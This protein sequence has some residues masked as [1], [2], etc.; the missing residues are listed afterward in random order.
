MSA[1]D[2]L[3]NIEGSTRNAI[4]IILSKM[5]AAGEIERVSRRKYALLGRPLGDGKERHDGRLY[6]E[7]RA[8]FYPSTL[9]GFEGR[10]RE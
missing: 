1:R 10:R 7:E 2:I 6:V 5:A 3:L 4:D 9:P 8:I